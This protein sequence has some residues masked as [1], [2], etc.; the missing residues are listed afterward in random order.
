MT[1]HRANIRNA[2][3]C[4]LASRSSSKKRKRSPRE[5][6]GVLGVTPYE[7]LT[8]WLRIRY[9]ISELE[10]IFGSNDFWLQRRIV[11]ARAYF[12]QA[13]LESS[14]PVQTNIEEA[15]EKAAIEAFSAA[16]GTDQS[17]YYAAPTEEIKGEYRKRALE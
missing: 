16:T 1:T 17:A 15:F 11:V 3:R 12:Q 9:G 4:R 8:S 13:L 7:I 2:R 10:F 6:A 5:S 14:L